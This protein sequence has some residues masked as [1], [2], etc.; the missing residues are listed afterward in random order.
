M[1]RTLDKSGAHGWTRATKRPLVRWIPLAAALACSS[2]D[3][4]APPKT[5][6]DDPELAPNMKFMG[7][8]ADGHPDV[9]GAKAAGQARAGRV[10][11]DGDIRAPANGRNRVR[12]G[13]YLMANDKIAAYIGSAAPSDGMQPFGGELLAIEAV[14]PDGMPQGKSNYGETMMMMSRQTLQPDEVT[15]LADGG[16]GKAAIVRASGKLA[17][18]GFLEPFKALFKDEYNLP[19]AIDYVLEPGAE[20]LAMRLSIG[21]NTLEEW[22]FIRQENVGFFHSYRSKSFT[23]EGGFAPQNGEVRSVFFDSETSSFALV[24]RG[25]ALKPGLSVAGFELY[26]GEA[27]GRIDPCSKKTVDFADF[28]AADGGLDAL[29]PAVQRVTGQPV[30]TAKQGK[31]VNSGDAPLAD[32]WVYALYPDGRVASRVRTDASGTFRLHAPDG[33]QVSVVASGYAPL[34]GGT[35]ADAMTLR[36]PAHATLVVR[37]REKDVGRPLPVRIQVLPK[38]AVP[39]AP[40]PWGIDAEAGG[41]LHQVFAMNGDAEIT[42]PPGQHRVIVSRGYEWELLDVEVTAMAGERVTVDAPLVHS[43]NTSN[44][45]CADF[46]IHT[47]FS[48]DS[49]DTVRDKVKSAVADGLDIP[50]S[51]EHEWVIDFQPTIRELGLEDFAFGFPSEELTTFTIGHFGIVPISPRP[52][53]RNNGAVEWIGKSI[54]DVFRS[55]NELPERPVIIVNHPSGDAFSGYLRG[56]GFDRTTGKGSGPKVADYSDEYAALEVW[57]DSDFEKNRTA[58]VAD[59][60][61]LL[62]L[63][64]NVWGVGNS[65]SH[66]LRSSPV[67]YPRTCL[68]FG[69]DDPRKLSAE[70]VRDALRAGKATI[71]GGL[72]MT[73]AGPGGEGPGATLADKSGGAFRIEVAAPTWVGGESL[74]TIIDGETVDVRPLGV[75]LASA[76]GKRWELSVDVRPRSSKARHWVVFHAKGTGDLAPLHPGRKPFAASNPVFF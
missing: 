46:H 70:I 69:H 48:F 44:V 53:R 50:V 24:S 4:V 49:D 16:D 76:T 73:V 33:A 34:A 75:P 36:M 3:K 55:V 45:M 38:V 7:G 41:R 15:V 30:W 32:V 66:S 19:F 20:K 21:N 6:C 5:T 17:T 13:D 11:T 65:D 72:Y 47:H 54:P 26:S 71:S 25:K 37:A 67:G 9:R 68:N 23:D 61:A 74:E 8:S 28:V 10:R 42:V 60:F 63:G 59:W 1:A 14:G 58:S 51:S 35:L 52:E 22:D 29:R 64:R 18:V 2:D 56:T 31:V 12:V 39:G 57:N 40:A 43:V 27:F 62:N